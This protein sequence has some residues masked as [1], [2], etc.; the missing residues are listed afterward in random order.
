MALWAWRLSGGLAVA[1][2]LV[3]QVLVANPVFERADVGVLPIANGL[4]LAYALPAI[5]AFAARR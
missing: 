2:V 3:I 1:T 5:L 4:L